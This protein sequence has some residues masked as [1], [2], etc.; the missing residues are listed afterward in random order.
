MTRVR[1]TL[2][3]AFLMG[4]AA[5]VGA[6]VAAAPALLDLSVAAAA[7]IGWALWLDRHPSA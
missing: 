3:A 6:V 4:T 7:A 2:G 1:K 5:A